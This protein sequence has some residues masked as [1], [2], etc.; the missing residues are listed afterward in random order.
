[1]AE[2]SDHL[3]FL[4]AC[5]TLIS[6]I[7][8][9]LLLL[10][11]LL[12][13]LQLLL[14]LLPLL[15]RFFVLPD[16]RLQVTLGLLP[17]LLFLG[18]GLSGLGD[19]DLGDAAG[20]EHTVPARHAPRDELVDAVGDH[21]APVLRVGA[22]GRQ[23]DG[24]CGD[25]GRARRG[26]R[27]VAVAHAVLLQLLARV[28]LRQLGHGH[29]PLADL[30]RAGGAER[31]AA[32]GHQRTVHAGGHAHHVV[33]HAIVLR[34]LGEAKGEGG[35]DLV[36]HLLASAL[37][38]GGFGHQVLELWPLRDVGPAELLGAGFGVQPPDAV[39]GLV[40]ARF[41]GPV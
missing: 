18:R 19:F 14:L 33:H 35:L 1:M 40:A 41:K 26:R 5:F 21:A 16:R 28:H 6:L 10:L 23:R 9:P 17:L 31:A 36:R 37:A 24:G 20:R 30:G 27:A 25:H 32:G 2:A 11:L 8:L 38:G 39:Q 29:A 4:F 3:L 13:L 12:L 22:A 7:S 15:L 34:I